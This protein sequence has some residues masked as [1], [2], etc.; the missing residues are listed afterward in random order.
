[1]RTLSILTLSLLLCSTSLYS[2]VAINTDSSQPDG[3]S[4]LDVKSTVKGIL[5]PRMTDAERDAIPNPA[6]GLLIYCTTDNRFYSNKGTPSIPDWAIIGSLWTANGNDIYYSSGNMGLGTATPAYRLDVSGDINY[7]GTLRQNGVP[8]TSG[9]LSVTASTPLSSSGGSDPDI[10]IQQA[11]SSAGGFLSSSDWST[12]NSKQ[13]ALIFG[14]LSSSDIQISGGTGSVIGTGT[15]LTINKGNFTETGSSVLTITGGTNAV[16]GSGTAILVKQANMGQS[17]YLSNSDWNAFNNKVSS[18]WTTSGTSISYTAGSVVIGNTTPAAS[19]VLDVNSTTNGVLLPRMTMVQRNAI[20]T[21]ADGLM[22]FCLDCGTEGAFSYYSNGSWKALAPCSNPA[23]TP[24]TN[25]PSQTQITWN[26]NAIPGAGGYKWNTTNDAGSAIDVGTNTS[27][28]ETGLT[29]GTSY[30]RYVWAYNGCGIS[31]PVSLSET[32]LACWYCGLPVTDARDSKLYNTVLIGTQCWMA[33][34]LN[35]GNRIDGNIE[36][37]NNSTIEKYCYSDQESNC[38]V[39][40]GLYQ[41]AEMVQYL[42]GATNTTSWNPVPTGNVIGICPAG[43]HIPS[44]AE[45]TTLT[46]YLGGE[47]IA[48][49]PMKETGTTHWSSPNTG[50]TNSSGFTALPGGYRYYGGGAFQNLSYSA[51]FWT[52]LENSPTTVWLRELDHNQEY[53]LRFNWNKTLGFS[54]RCVKE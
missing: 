5:I 44:D 20:T 8:F 53:A 31:A 45:W 28:N 26:W 32:T 11:G 43:W 6:T 49:G 1:M 52:T 17:G 16:L 18:Q 51:H 21:P 9:I 30:T 47:A 50:A 37:T 24:G 36:Q 4:M 41:W 19:A 39:Y 54:V 14:D 29:C 23:P 25:V 3:S 12:F 2:Q 15:A 48:G 7:T 10:S 40:G 34:N 27:H 46:S 22:V 33:Q 13:N 42:N 35:I 38:D